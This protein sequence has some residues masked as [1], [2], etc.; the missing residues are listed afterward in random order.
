MHDDSQA[1][2]TEIA[3]RPDNV[4][5]KFWNAETGAVNQDA[6]LESHAYYEK[7]N[8][9]QSGGES[10][11]QDFSD[12]VAN[13]ATG[14]TPD[15]TIT[16]STEGPAAELFTA[17]KMGE[18]AAAMAENGSLSDEHLA[19]FKA[20]GIPD[21]V[22]AKIGQ[23]FVSEAANFEGE[24][25]ESVGGT[26]VF[27][28]VAQWYGANADQAALDSYNAAVSGSDKGVAML[29]AKGMMAEYQKANGRLPQHQVNAGGQNIP[30]GIQPFT[31]WKEA[32]L[33]M[34]SKEYKANP[35]V[36]DQVAARMKVSAL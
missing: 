32:S 3:S 8:G 11:V 7:R 21:E 36:R 25:I 1:P 27:Q 9:E 5:E 14:D 33:A 24:L 13:Q 12:N 31:S 2:A 30:S 6:L 22:A 17:D 34:G 20:T 28:K 26:E 29:A 4:P 19:A 16:P 35:A 18:Y 15:L 10:N 23:A